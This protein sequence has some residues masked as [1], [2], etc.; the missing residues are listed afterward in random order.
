MP[1]KEIIMDYEIQLVACCLLDNALI[2][3]AVSAGTQP[4]WFTNKLAQKVWIEMVKRDEDR[5][6][7]DVL[8]ADDLVKKYTGKSDPIFLDATNNILSVKSELKTAIEFMDRDHL[9]K[10][11]IDILSS[12]TRN[13]QDEDPRIIASDAAYKLMQLEEDN[14][15][16]ETKDVEERI[17]ACIHKGIV[18]YGFFSAR[19]LGERH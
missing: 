15:E 4:D 3:I 16:Q 6:T 8:W 17:I 11:V 18:S 9:R 5:K 19:L 14:R 13:L 7:V 2:A 12:A 1:R 10:Q